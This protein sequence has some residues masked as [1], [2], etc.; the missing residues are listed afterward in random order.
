[1]QAPIE[2]KYKPTTAFWKIN[3]LLNKGNFLSAIKGGQGASKTISLEMLIIDWFYNNP[4]KEITICSA[5]KTKLIGTAFQDFKKIL[6]DW[7]LWEQCKWRDNTRLTMLDSTTG[8]IEFIGLDVEDIGK[9]R[10]RD[11][12]Y[13]NE[14]NKITRE[15]YIDIT[16]RAKR[17]VCDWNPDKEFFITEF[18]KEDNILVLTYKD[19]EYLP[20]QERKTIESALPL[21]FHDPKADNLFA[22]ENIKNPYWANWWK[23]YGLGL[24]GQLEG[25]IFNYWRVGEFDHSLPYIWGMD[26]GQSDPHTLIKVAID[27]K[28]MKIYIDEYHYAPLRSSGDVLQLLAKHCKKNE[29][30]IADINK[31]NADIILQG[32]NLVPAHKPPGSVQ[33]GIQD[34]QDYELIITERSKNVKKELENYIWLDKKGDIPIDAWNH[35]I[36]PTRYVL[37]YFRRMF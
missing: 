14:V 6:L 36:D 4:N 18:L 37:K 11:L 12:V 20:D 19:N 9:G 3:D 5:E 27:N 25:A 10:R 8:F 30:I 26:W 15:K 33:K 31:G 32:Y 13:I 22:E 28:K 29:L 34:M 21:G 24:D 17:V 7:N 2:Y 16:R 1:M 35:T 23:V